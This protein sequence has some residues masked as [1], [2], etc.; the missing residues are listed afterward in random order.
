MQTPV[1]SPASGLSASLGNAVIAITGAAN[2]IGLTLARHFAANGARVVIADLDI[3]RATS[4]ARELEAQGH[5]VLPIALDVRNPEECRRMVRDIANAFGR[6]DVMVCNAGIVGIKQFFD[7]EEADWDGALAVNIK[8]VFFCMQAAARQMMMQEPLSPG[9][10]RGKIINMASIAGRYIGGPMA[11]YQAPYR[12]TKA[13]VIS[14]TQTAAHTLAPHITANAICPGLV[15]TDMWKRIDSALAT[16]ENGQEGD[17][18]ARR[19]S[20]V[21]MGRAQTPDDIA[22][23]AL[24]LASAASD[25]MTGQAT[26]IDGGLVLS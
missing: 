19:V 16:I 8:G 4:A 3:E 5:T 10:P 1:Q 14:L 20:T 6:L 12:A 15:A 22:G 18:F 21:P 17:A 23:L 13:A 2:G 26:N 24:F 7:L 9:R 25:Y 11:Q